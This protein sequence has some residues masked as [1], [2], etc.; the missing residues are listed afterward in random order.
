MVISIPAVVTA[1]EPRGLRYGLLTAANGP[2]DL[3]ESGRDGGL[4]Y[5]PVS[6]GT[7]HSYPVEC[8]VDQPPTAKV[9][10]PDDPWVVA[11]PFVAYA[12]LVCGSAGHTP[13]ELEAKVARRLANAE[14]TIAEQAMAEVLTAVAGAAIAVVAPADIVSVVGA[15]EQWL[16]AT[17]GYGNVGYLHASPRL[18]AYAT[19]AQLVVPD[20]PVLR[21][22]MGTVWVFGGG[23]PDGTVFISG[24]T[25][26]WRSPEPFVYPAAQVFDRTNN[27]YKLLAEREYA[28][29]F[30]LFAA[31]A[32][33]IEAS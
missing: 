16:Y 3:P 17:S 12:S 14:Q 25:T 19:A 29:A 10:D 22:R 32:D 1:P 2:L 15:L 26:V 9:F 28:V 13:A 11:E 4:T 21:T 5:E 20:G 24:Q 18:A 27:Q 8:P 33:F 7:G 6:G 30:D 23:Y 31:K